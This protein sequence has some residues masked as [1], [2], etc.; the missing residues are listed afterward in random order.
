MTLDANLALTLDLTLSLAPSGPQQKL[1]LGFPQFFHFSTEPQ[2]HIPAEMR[3]DAAEESEKTLMCNHQGLKRLLATAQM[4][5]IGY[6]A[7]LAVE[8]DLC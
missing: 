2:L 8:E 7:Y 5:R 1:T 4:R 3:T 6:V